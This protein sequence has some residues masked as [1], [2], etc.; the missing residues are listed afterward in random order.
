MPLAS[1]RIGALDLASTVDIGGLRISNEP[2]QVLLLSHTDD[3]F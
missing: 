2:L 1:V 3:A